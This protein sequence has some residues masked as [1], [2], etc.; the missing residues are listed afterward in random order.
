MVKKDV[1]VLSNA[2]TKS[3]VKSL[4]NAKN[5]NDV[6]KAIERVRNIFSKHYKMIKNNTF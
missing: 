5:D 6:E 1:Q 2:E 3:F 4:N